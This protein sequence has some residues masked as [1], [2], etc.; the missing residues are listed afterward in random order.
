MA[1]TAV[2]S[3]G[4]LKTDTLARKGVGSHLASAAWRAA[5][6]AGAATGAS[7]GAQAAHANATTPMERSSELTLMAG[8]PLAKKLKVNYPSTSTISKQSCS[9]SYRDF[10]EARYSGYLMQPTHCCLPLNRVGELR[11]AST[12]MVVLREGILIN[13]LFSG[14]LEAGE[15]GSLVSVSTRNL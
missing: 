9:G 8:L 5:S 12:S 4:I 13:N 11:F 14:F 2:G 3:K 7:G 1:P 10:S 6:V 15:L